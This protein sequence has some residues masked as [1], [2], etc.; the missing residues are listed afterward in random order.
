M[1]H[2]SRD[3][4]VKKLVR[5]GVINQETDLFGPILMQHWRSL[6]ACGELE[7]ATP[8]TFQA[9]VTWMVENN[10]LDSV[11][12]GFLESEVEAMFRH[13]DKDNKGHLTEQQFQD[14]FSDQFACVQPV[15]MTENFSIS[16]GKSVMKLDVGAAIRRAAKADAAAVS[17]AGGC[18]QG[19]MI[20]SSSKVV[21]K[22]AS[23]LT[24]R[25]KELTDCSSGPLLEARVKMDE[26][27][28]K[29][30]PATLGGSCGGWRHVSAFQ[31]T[32]EEIKRKV[33]EAAK[34]CEQ[35]Q[36]KARVDARDQRLLDSFSKV[37]TGRGSETK[38]G[39]SKDG[40]VGVMIHKLDTSGR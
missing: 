15:S 38:R 22:A 24:A 1:T 10:A 21:N 34:E 11:S 26:F 6:W 35:E 8:A 4:T 28:V 36:R 32:V 31:R 29:A 5:I 16:D 14:I 27:R 2:P 17:V 23:F 40:W 37:S 13:L 33:G 12:E 19:G 39:R 25:R 3:S 20:S 30:G 18:D 7:H 9:F